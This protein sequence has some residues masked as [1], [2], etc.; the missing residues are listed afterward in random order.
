VVQVAHAESD[1]FAGNAHD[2]PPVGH[3]APRGDRQIGADMVRT[4]RPTSTSNTSMWAATAGP[5]A[6]AQAARSGSRG[7]R[8]S[9][10]APDSPAF[11]PR[12]TCPTRYPDLRIVVLEAGARPAHGALGPQR[13]AWR[14]TGLNGG[15]GPRRGAGPSAVRR[16]DR[17]PSDVDRKCHPRPTDPRR[18]VPSR[19]GLPRGDVTRSRRADAVRHKAERWRRSACR[20]RFLEGVELTQKVARA[21]CR[22][23][24]N[25]RPEPPGCCTVWA[26]LRLWWSGSFAGAESDIFEGSPAV[27]D[28]R[29]RPTIVVTTPSGSVRAHL[30]GARDERL[31]AA[32]SGTSRPECSRSTRT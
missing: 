1:P 10:W 25:V 6:P 11:P 24:R 32:P 13:W 26:F 20:F 18:A 12:G 19:D 15:R 16:H 3:D 17:R 30:D 22:S 9:W 4:G 5:A 21:G 23:A 2:G 31:L 7:R 29:R 28:R 8:R 27:T 14:S